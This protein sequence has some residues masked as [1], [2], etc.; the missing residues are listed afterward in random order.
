[1]ISEIQASFKKLNDLHVNYISL[2]KRFQK[3]QSDFEPRDLL[4]FAAANRA[5]SNIRGF[6]AVFEQD[7]YLLGNSIIRLQLDTILRF[8]A[9]E[10]VDDP[11]DLAVKILKGDKI[12]K[13]QDRNKNKMTDRNLCRLFVKET[14]SPGIENVYEHACNFIHLSKT[15]VSAIFDYQS[16]QMFD[17]ESITDES[18]MT[19]T[20]GCHGGNA[21]SDSLKIE[22][23]ECMCCITEILY[24]YMEK[25]LI[26]SNENLKKIQNMLTTGKTEKDMQQILIRLH[27]ELSYDYIC[28]SSPALKER[29][30]ELEKNIVFLESEVDMH[31]NTADFLQKF[32][33][34]VMVEFVKNTQD[35]NL[36]LPLKDNCK[37]HKK[38]SLHDIE[39]CHKG[40]VYFLE[41]TSRATSLVDKYIELRS[42]LNNYLKIASIFHKK[43]NDLKEQHPIWANS[44]WHFPGI[45]K[46]L[47]SY[48]S[49]EQKQVLL[50][51]Y[52][53][54]NSDNSEVTME[55]FLAKINDWIYLNKY[56]Y[57]NFPEILPKSLINDLRT[58]NL[59]VTRHGPEEDQDSLNNF[60]NHLAKCV[61]QKIVDKLIKEYCRKNTPVI[62][63]ISLVTM[64]DFRMISS[65]QILFEGITKTLNERLGEAVKASL[66]GF[67]LVLMSDMP[68]K[69]EK[70]KLY[71][72]VLNNKIQYIAA[73]MK[74][75]DA[76]TVDDLGKG[77]DFS[78]PD[79][80]S[81]LLALKEDILL[82]TSKR[83]HTL[84]EK[85]KSES[86]KEKHISHLMDGVK[87]LYAIVIDTTWLNWFPEKDRNK[88]Y[89]GIIYNSKMEEKLGRIFDAVIPYRSQLNFEE[90]ICRALPQRTLK[91]NGD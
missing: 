9:L 42:Y 77:N 47:L 22:S 37:P 48:F 34:L 74:L 29:M 65:P 23:A 72:K 31:E 54:I 43:H 63:A 50:A 2:I 8:F 55:L 60:Y 6:I 4:F 32:F 26:Q 30:D 64:K 39:F 28:Y 36:H 14:Q 24:L 84:P 15:H 44:E 33:E 88:N 80:L 38:P 13:L 35:F 51:E 69:I 82:V 87:N 73:E 90:I 66:E 52:Q 56:V 49:G 41:C 53:K 25:S 16:V 75:I 3:K 46:Q 89:Y 67:D 21:V 12:Q 83:G 71:V 40:K 79:I 76:I 59:L 27:N 58:V 91:Q 85:F 68:D 5:I 10:L 18:K 17:T 61:A 81:G 20:L 7:N 78:I 62:L 1:M 11:N 45:V 19:Y 70:N 86:L 57:L